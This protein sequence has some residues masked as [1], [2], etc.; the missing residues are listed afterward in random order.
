MFFSPV[1][2]YLT[3]EFSVCQNYYREEDHKT[4]KGK[5]FVRRRNCVCLV[6]TWLLKVKPAESNIQHCTIFRERYDSKLGGLCL[7]HV[8][9]VLIRVGK[10]YFDGI[11]SDTFFLT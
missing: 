4:L 8:L 10:E 9:C 3:K 11:H 1:P 6:E 5:S 7:K 2:N